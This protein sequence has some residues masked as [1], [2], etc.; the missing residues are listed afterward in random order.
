M[1]ELGSGCQLGQI[2]HPFLEPV[3]DRLHIVIGDGLDF[4][5]TGRI[6]G[7]EIGRQFVQALTGSSGK[8]ADFGQTR[9]RQRLQPGDFDLDAVVHEAGFRQQRA[10]G[11]G[12]GSITAIQR[13]EGGQRRK[14]GEIR[15]GLSAIRVG[16]DS[17]LF[18]H[19]PAV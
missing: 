13:R 14:S 5:D 19:P 10:Q 6:V 15:H 12:F 1:D 16:N 8:G 4:L 7:I 17:L 18:Y 9:F 11:V 3:F 2:L